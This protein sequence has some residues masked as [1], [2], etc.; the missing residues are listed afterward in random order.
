MPVPEWPLISCTGEP[1]QNTGVWKSCTCGYTDLKKKKSAVWQTYSTVKKRGG[2]GVWGDVTT[3]MSLCV[4][5]YL[6]RYYHFSKY[7]ESF[8]GKGILNDLL[9]GKVNRGL[10]LTFLNGGWKPSQCVR[11]LALHCST[12]NSGYIKAPKKTTYIRHNSI[13][14]TRHWTWQKHR[15]VSKIHHWPSK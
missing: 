10:R 7:N 8:R 12:Y 3:F 6:W 9:E 5:W 2:M 15:P 11:A 1:Q 4:M 13:E 14:C